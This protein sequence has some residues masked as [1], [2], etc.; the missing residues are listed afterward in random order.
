MIAG[1][2]LAVNPLAGGD[3]FPSVT[4]GTGVGRKRRS[5]LAMTVSLILS[6]AGA[7]VELGMRLSNGIALPRAGKWL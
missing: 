7:M 2:G 6:G 3:C 1:V 4:L 5:L